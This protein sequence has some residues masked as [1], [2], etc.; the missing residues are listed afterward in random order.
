MVPRYILI[1]LVI[2]IVLI[3]IYKYNYGSESASNPV[4]SKFSFLKESFTPTVNKI[5]STDPN[6]NLSTLSAND[7]VSQAFAASID[8]TNPGSMNLNNISNLTSG[9]TDTMILNAPGGNIWLRSKGKDSVVAVS[10]E[11]G[12]TGNLIVDND[13]TV[14]HD[15]VCNHWARVDGNM[16]VGELS[17]GDWTISQD[18]NGNLVFNNTRNTAGWITQE[19]SLFFNK[20]LNVLGNVSSKGTVQVGSGNILY[21]PSSSGDE[22][23]FYNK[24]GRFVALYPGRTN[25]GAQ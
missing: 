14:R 19:G 23:R 7:I 25:I 6:G 9:P 17:I 21:Y 3:I 5:L 18:V 16:R 4:L 11:N 22:M 10:A 24:D 15:F 1:M 8:D 2:L 20:D 13:M 12:G